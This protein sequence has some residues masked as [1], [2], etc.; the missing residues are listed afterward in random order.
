MNDALNALVQ[1]G[2]TVEI[3][4]HTDKN[5]FFCLIY[6]DRAPGTECDECGEP[7]TGYG[8]CSHGS[9]PAEAFSKELFQRLKEWAKCGESSTLSG[10]VTGGL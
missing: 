6:K 5:G 10:V 1:H 4:P 3:G 2:Y 9:T 7:Q 8:Q